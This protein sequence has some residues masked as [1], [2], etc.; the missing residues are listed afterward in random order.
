M[1]RLNASVFQTAHTRRCVR[2]CLS[3]AEPAA[4]GDDLYSRPI[5]H[6]AHPGLPFFSEI[7]HQRP[8]L[9]LSSEERHVRRV[10]EDPRNEEGFIRPIPDR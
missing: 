10:K 2:Y 1:W 9:P 6:E 5:H 8:I 4:S 7:E 3:A